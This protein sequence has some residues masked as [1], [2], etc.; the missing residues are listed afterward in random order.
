MLLLM[1][2][3]MMLG[4]SLGRRVQIA[5]SACISD[6]QSTS[7]VYQWPRLAGSNQN[8]CGENP[9]RRAT[10]R[11]TNPTKWDKTNER[12]FDRRAK[13]QFRKFDSHRCRECAKR[14]MRN[15]NRTEEGTRWKLR[16]KKRRAKETLGIGGIWFMERVKPNQTFHPTWLTIQNRGEE[17]AKVHIL[18]IHRL[19]N[20]K[21]KQLHVQ[22]FSTHGISA[23]WNRILFSL[24]CVPQR[25]TLS[26]SLSL[27]LYVCVCKCLYVVVFYERDGNRPG[28]HKKVLIRSK[29]ENE[30][31]EEEENSFTATPEKGQYL[32]LQVDRIF[33]SFY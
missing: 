10:T 9:H 25:L 17:T 13:K 18:C 16:R 21:Y 28:H 14:Q 3:L 22:E 23:H 30:K 7:S 32:K 29:V 24:F 31:K 2:S 4:K 8:T 15:D 1:L 6:F 19:S 33:L 27:P 5:F 20:V 26:L 12:H 11:P